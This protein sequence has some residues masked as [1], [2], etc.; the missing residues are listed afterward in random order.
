MDNI[1]NTITLTDL[2]KIIV[3][4]CRGNYYFIEDKLA[5]KKFISVVASDVTLLNTLELIPNIH[6]DLKHFD[7]LVKWEIKEELLI[8]IV[9][10]INSSI[11]EKYIHSDFD[12][13]ENIN[14]YNRENFK[15]EFSKFCNDLLDNLSK[16]KISISL[17]DFRFQSLTESLNKFIGLNKNTKLNFEINTFYNKVFQFSPMT[18]ELSSP[19]VDV[20]YQPAIKLLA[21][22]YIRIFISGDIV[23]N[24]NN[25]KEIITIMY[26]NSNLKDELLHKLLCI[27]NQNFCLK[28]QSD[29]KKD[30]VKDEEFKDEWDR[31]V[32][33]NIRKELVQEGFDVFLQHSSFVSGQELGSQIEQKLN[34]ERKF[35]PVDKIINKTVLRLIEQISYKQS[36]WGQWLREINLVKEEILMDKFQE[37]ETRQS[38][39]NI[40]S[41][42]DDKINLL[43]Q[44]AKIDNLNDLIRAGEEKQK[45]EGRKSNHLIY[46]KEIGLKIQNIIE[47][48]INLSLKEIIEIIESSTDKK[49]ATIEEQ[50]GQDFIIY[51]SEKPIYYIEVK[52]RWDSEGIVALSKRQVECCAKNKSNYAVIT[53]NVANYKAKNKIDM[54][55]IS[56]EDLRY[57]VKVNL[58]LGDDF[59]TLIKEN[60]AFEKT[61]DNTKL[62]EFRGHIPQKRIESNGILFDEFITK[63]KKHLIDA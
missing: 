27:P 37:E 44:L 24:I 16:D 9:D 41:V 57:D 38:L 8:N 17:T 34:P 45:E 56:F 62:I 33:G 26:G 23:I 31:I 49:L 46:I 61:V 47:N 35:I 30:N 59:E 32:G 12:F 50:N 14:S 28:S 13:L 6:G 19:T 15:E 25:L 1:F 48:E 20:N 7:K 18:N 4:N 5:Y 51:K 36:T 39:F 22:L 11:S 42:N 3:E 29:L 54:E 53:V 21:Y 55:N 60:N 58:D 40:L 63:L 52:S 43:G 2:G 10:T